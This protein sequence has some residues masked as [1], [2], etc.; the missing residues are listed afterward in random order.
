MT[1]SN[2]LRRG[3]PCVVAGGLLLAAAGG[4]AAQGP[5]RPA[6]VKG[7]G[8]LRICDV[9]G[10]NLDSAS[11][12]F[13]EQGDDFIT[14]PDAPFRSSVSCLGRQQTFYVLASADPRNRGGLGY[15]MVS[16]ARIAVDAEPQFT[17]ARAES[18]ITTPMC[19]ES[20]AVAQPTLRL[21][22]RSRASRTPL[23]DCF[24]ELLRESNGVACSSV[25]G[26]FSGL[27]TV[28]FIDSQ[29][30]EYRPGE[31]V[32]LTQSRV[33][34]WTK[35]MKLFPD[36]ANL[37]WRLDTS[38]SGTLVSKVRGTPTASAFGDF[39]F[40]VEGVRNELTF[41]D[42][43]LPASNLRVPG[44]TRPVVP[45]PP[46]FI[47]AGDVFPE[48]FTLAI[49]PP[50]GPITVN[51]EFDL[52]VMAATNGAAVTGMSGN[53]DGQDI[54][55]PLAACLQPT[56]P[57]SGVAGAIYTCRGLSGGFLAG[58]LGDGAHTLSINVSL[59]DGRT[60]TDSATWTIRR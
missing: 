2:W 33:S 58:I 29:G 9:D 12:Q 53:I 42:C 47:E 10:G 48:D 50:T 22:A 37:V 35:T 27:G 32:D 5:D 14:G 34:K 28:G 45:V 44:I 31:F 30:L 43:Q 4:A 40:Y 1:A 52:S 16:Q 49:S 11:D 7:N 26:R 54:S 56:A 3:A 15:R 60:I 51:Q 36:L 20:D 21:I 24:D 8:T 46:W 13:F 39:R 18:G 59:S 57:L 41:V 17:E 23:E 55:G 19:V 6:Y 38:L 25:R